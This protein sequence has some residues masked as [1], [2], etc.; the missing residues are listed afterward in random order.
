MTKIKDIHRWE[1]S[2]VTLLNLDGWT[3]NHTGEGSVSWDA[4]GKTPFPK[5]QDCVI[6]MKF[7]NKYYETKIIEKAKFDKLIATGKVALYFVNDPKGN[8]LFWLNNL[9]DLEVKKMYCP[10]T[11]LWGSKKV[12]KPCYLL[13]ESDAAIV[14]I[15]EEDTEL[16]IWD[17]YFKME[18]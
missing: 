12:S 3:L 1:Q 7:R 14:N 9:K 18:D 17:S 6:E 16:G 15:N 2:V 11:T 10:D 5:S 13:K 4:E 8:Y